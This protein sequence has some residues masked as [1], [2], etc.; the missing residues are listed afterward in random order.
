MR[1]LRCRDDINA[2]FGS[3]GRFGAARDSRQRG[4]AGQPLFPR[5]THFG[6][7]LNPKNAASAVEQ[8]T[9]EDAGSV[10]DIR[11][12]GLPRQAALVVQEIDDFGWISRSIAHVVVHARGEALGWV[13]GSHAMSLAR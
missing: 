12:P 11:D 2:L 6:I 1:R 9:G 4:V 13:A 8:E 3:G 10:G 5:P 7:R